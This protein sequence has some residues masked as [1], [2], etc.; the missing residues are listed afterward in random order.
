MVILLAV[1]VIAGVSGFGIGQGAAGGD[2][3]LPTAA[4][5]VGHPSLGSPDAPVTIVEY[6]D[7]K[8]P[9][10]G[11]YA[12]EVEPVLVDRY[13]RQG[14]VRIEWRDYPAQGSESTA[15]AIAGR[16]ADAQGKFW[17]FH[18]YVYAN[19]ER[20]FDEDAIREAAR[21]IGLDLARFDEDRATGGYALAARA[22]FDEGRQR[23]VSG[24]PT[25]FIGDRA[26]VGAQPVEVFVAA[27]EQALDQQ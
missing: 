25:F 6:S 5:D 3:T 17:E 23:G 19:Q 14:L 18:N 9:F 13:V 27:I 11:R 2:T 20:T 1:A 8:C 15:L 21:T 24:T 16:A 26:V 12:R 7:F 4:T 10:C 22:D